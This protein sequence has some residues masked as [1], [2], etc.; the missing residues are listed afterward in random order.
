MSFLS[1]KK[2]QPIVIGGLVAILLAVGVYF[3]FMTRPPAP[4]VTASS[5][6]GATNPATLGAPTPPPAPAAI[7]AAAAQTS[8]AQPPASPAPGM[9]GAA[10]TPVAAAAGPQTA[11][12]L[13]PREKFRADP[14]AMLHPPPPRGKVTPPPEV[15]PYPTWLIVP[16][17]KPNDGPDQGG[18]AP[19][20]TPRRMAGVLFGQTVSAI[21]ET[22]TETV[23]VR[24]GDL[25]ENSQMR[26]EK[27]EPNR[28]VLKSTAPGK[29][30]YVIVKMAAGL[31]IPGATGVSTTTTTPGSSGFPAVYSR[32]TTPGSR[33]PTPGR[34]GFGGGT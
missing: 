2:N 26:V 24:P 6:T 30:R 32:P 3:Y 23:V 12:P 22:G 11:G 17:P 8:G 10:A 33:P 1:D 14:F 5:D 13:K 31:A 19:D 21:L 7:P 16:R 18:P 20:T 15:I 28:I 25:V 34:P 4:D 27:I 9:A 29:A